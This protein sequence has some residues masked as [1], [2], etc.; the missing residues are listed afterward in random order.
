MDVAEEDGFEG[1]GEGSKGGCAFVPE[2]KEKAGGVLAASRS[3][4]K[5]KGP[6]RSVVV[7][8]SGQTR[9]G[10]RDAKERTRQC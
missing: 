9:R 3:L 10:K 4:G 1:G 8:R 6:G 5:V 7:Y 2:L